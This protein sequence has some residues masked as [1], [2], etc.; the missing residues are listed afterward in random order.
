PHP[1]A[2][3]NPDRQ[4]GERPGRDGPALAG[5]PADG[6]DPHGTPGRCE[7][8]HHRFRDHVDPARRRDRGAL[9]PFLTKIHEVGGTAII[10]LLLQRELAP[11][12]VI[13]TDGL[14]SP[15]VVVES[16]LF[17]ETRGKD[18]SLMVGE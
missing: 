16:A 11:G 2:G 13:D 3:S 4:A 7:R 18:F 8:D 14:T 5:G 15:Y 12:T 1:A 17:V 10:E 9:M 6:G